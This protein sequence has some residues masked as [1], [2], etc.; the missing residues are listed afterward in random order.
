MM[1]VATPT[2]FEP[3]TSALKAV[4]LSPE[5]RF[6]SKADSWS[7]RRC[8]CFAP[9]ADTAQPSGDVRYGPLA[10]AAQSGFDVRFDPE[11]C[12]G[13]AAIGARN[14]KGEAFRNAP[15]HGGKKCQLWVIQYRVD[16]KGL[17]TP[18]PARF[19]RKHFRVRLGS[20]AAATV[21]G[22]TS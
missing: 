15:I 7:E 22:A 19:I 12:R 21:R 4:A 11:S 6:G 17:N 2:G 14:I 8:G 9:K 5:L 3:A 20:L 10:A 13:S 16:Q 18:L 1:V